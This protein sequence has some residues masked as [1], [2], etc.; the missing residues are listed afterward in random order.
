MKIILILHIWLLQAIW[1]DISLSFKNEK[2]KL[3]YFET[4]VNIVRYFSTD[5]AMQVKID[6]KYPETPVFRRNQYW[7][8]SCCFFKVRKGFTFLSKIRNKIICW[9]YKTT[10]QIIINKTKKQKLWWI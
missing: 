2:K 7:N 8:I 9:R 10:N 3:K 5:R 1:Y 6:K 4:N